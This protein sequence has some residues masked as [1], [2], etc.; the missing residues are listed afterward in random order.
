VTAT[1]V[2]CDFVRS[3]TTWCDALRLTWPKHTAKCVERATGAS[4]AAVHSW[5]HQGHAPPFNA[6][7]KIAGACPELAA[8]LRWLL[9][10]D[11]TN[12]VRNEAMQASRR[13]AD[14]LDRAEGR[15]ARAQNRLDREQARRDRATAGT[16]VTP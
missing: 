10:D 14:R 3:D 9:S 13:E 7:M 5:I 2:N 11:I 15:A 12:E 16:G 4:Q 6:A 1:V 8:T